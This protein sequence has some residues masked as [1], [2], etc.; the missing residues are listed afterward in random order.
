MSLFFLGHL[1][2]SLEWLIPSYLLLGLCLGPLACARSTFI[3][4]LVNK[5]MFVLEDEEELQEALHGNMKES[6]LRRLTRALQV[7]IIF[8]R[9]IIFIRIFRYEMMNVMGDLRTSSLKQFP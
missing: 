3:L 6:L 8:I 4:T 1:Y 2:P 9:D 5:L 7:F